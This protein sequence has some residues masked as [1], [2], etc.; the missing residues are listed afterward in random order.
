ML[1]ALK[2]HVESPLIVVTRAAS[3]NAEK[4]EEIRE[5]LAKGPNFQDFV[6]NPDYSKSEW[7]NYEGKLRREKGEEQRLRLPPWLKTTIPMGKNYAK[8]KNQLREL[9][10]STVCEEARCPNIGECWGGGEHGTQTATIMLMGDTC[11]R[12]CRFCSVKTARKP[13]P[14]DENEPVNTATAIASWGLDYIVLTSVDRDD[15]PDGGSKHIAK[16]VKE[17]KARNSNI[18]VECLVPDFRGDLGCVETI[19]N[20]GLDVYAHN[21]E[22]VEKLTP[23][24][25]DRRAHYRQTLK[26]LSEAKRF[27]PNL[28]TKSSIMLGLGETDEEVENTLKDL[29]EAGVD[30][31]TLGQYMQPTNKH[32]KVIEYVTPE[33]FKH[34]EDRGNQ[35]GFLYTASGPLVRSSYKA[36]EFFITSILE[37]RKKRQALNSKPEQ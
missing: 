19:A 37:N 28:I 12:G 11:T 3:T 6:Q 32:L 14:L 4:L 34:W 9:K 31:I 21:I 25:R 26:V 13:P 24:V 27:N 1:R 10:L 23:Y 7:E 17:I 33:K 36:G 5:R 18:F 20:C 29:R 2:G 30:C 22:T 35:L 8:I 15:L 16:T